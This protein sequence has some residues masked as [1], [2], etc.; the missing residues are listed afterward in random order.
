MDEEKL[1]IAKQMIYDQNIE[2]VL[3][4]LSDIH[5]SELLYVYA[6]NYNWDNGFAIPKM[7]YLHDYC[8]LSTA[9]MLFYLAD[10]VRYLLNKDEENNNLTEWLLFIKDLYKRIIAA[11][12]KNSHIKFTPP[13]SKVQISKLKKEI[14]IQ[15][16]VFLEQT[17]NIDLN[18]TL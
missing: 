4:E 3:T 18:I 17:G 15:E 10:G 2:E 14:T 12:F 7:I 11:K 6:Y 8:D 13:L 5:D 9:L 1:K 16:N